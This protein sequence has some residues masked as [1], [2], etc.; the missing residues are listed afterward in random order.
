MLKQLAHWLPVT[1]PLVAVACVAPDVREFPRPDLLAPLEANT[2]PAVAPV[3]GDPYPEVLSVVSGEREGK[4]Y[5]AHGR[6]FIK[7][8]AIDV[9]RALQVDAVVVD[10]PEVHA[11][12]SEPSNRPEFAFSMRVSHE[13]KN[14]L[15]IEYDL[16]WVHEL[17]TGDA[18]TPLEVVGQWEKTSGTVHIEVMR[19]SFV[20]RHVTPEVT[21]IE[22]IKHLKAA[23]RDNE[24][25]EAYFEH[26]YGDLRAQVLGEALPAL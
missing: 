7:A 2:A 25:L 19:G 21:E 18:D 1:V 6:A 13:V 24:T 14:I 16:D 12:T 9:W 4:L 5:Y 20:V 10:R 11:W 23:L 15:N 3:G 22:V 8:P 26:L 17:Q